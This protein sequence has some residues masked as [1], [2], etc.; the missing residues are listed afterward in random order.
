MQL[1]L[2]LLEDWDNDPIVEE[3]P[4]EKQPEVTPE[5]KPVAEDAAPLPEPTPEELK[6][7]LLAILNSL[8]REEFAGIDSIN[9][10]IL[11]IQSAAPDRKDLLALL[12]TILDEKTIHAGML[13]KAVTS[14]D[15]DQEVLMNQGEEKAEDILSEPASADLDYDAETVAETPDEED[16]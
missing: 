8:L 9:S 15:G 7:S 10:A 5:D 1:K 3:Q 16:K 4:V 11:S 6:A 12:S 2:N 13:T 14:F